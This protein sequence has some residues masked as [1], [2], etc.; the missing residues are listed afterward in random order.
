MVQ[1]AFNLTS[2]CGAVIIEKRT[3]FGLLLR[4]SLQLVNLKEYLTGFVG[5][6]L[7]VGSLLRSEAL[8]TLGTPTH[9]ALSV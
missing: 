4:K 1:P 3:S 5:T 2:A 9:I 6:H 7:I 8:E